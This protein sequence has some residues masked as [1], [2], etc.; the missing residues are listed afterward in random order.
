MTYHLTT[1]FRLLTFYAREAWLDARCK[2]CQRLYASAVARGDP[3]AANY[4]MR[5]LER[6]AGWEKR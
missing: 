5:R 1:F 4:W 6:V 3:A 2:S